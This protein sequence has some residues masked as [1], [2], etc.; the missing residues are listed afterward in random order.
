MYR[1]GAALSSAQGAQAALLAPNKRVSG[2]RE[3]GGTE[4]T[5]V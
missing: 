2:A 3:Q 1:V 4:G 5:A